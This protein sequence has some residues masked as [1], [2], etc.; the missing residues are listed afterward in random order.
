[1]ILGEVVGRVWS[2]RQHAGLDGRRLVLVRDPDSGA[3]HV[4]VDLLDA[5]AGMTVLLAT[6]E[7]AAIGLRH[8]LGRRRGGR[9][10]LRLRRPTRVMT[11]L[12]PARPRRGWVDGPPVQRAWTAAP[13][14]QAGP[15][16]VPRNG[17]WADGRTGPSTVGLGGP[18]TRRHLLGPLR[19]RSRSGPGASARAGLDGWR[20][21][22]STLGGCAT[23]PTGAAAGR[24]DER[25]VDRAAGRPGR[26][27]P[28][29]GRRQGRGAAAAAGA[30]RPGAGRVR[31]Q[32]GRVHRRPRRVHPGPDRGAAARVAARRRA[33]PGGGGRGGG[34]GG[35][36]GGGGRRPGAG[37]GA[38]RLHRAR[39]RARSRCA[40]RRRPRTRPTPPTPA[41]TT[42]TWSC[43]ARTPWRTRCAAAG[44]ACTPAVRCPT[45]A[46]A[47][48]AR[49]PWWCRAW[50]RPGRPA[51]S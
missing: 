25:R 16:R 19:H 33:G 35:R 43:T 49:W 8:P 13:L 40:P 9:P 29:A 26:R 14:I 36:A 28:R 22:A 23:H 12:R 37:R 32:H 44:P 47:T 18:S 6:D 3:R 27:G 42:A 38:R 11:A 39:A 50:C 24:R 21:G 1:M 10:R 17:R 48:R 30:R 51:C 45:G 15:G 31:G 5:A 4:A 20:I 7:A 2:E 34:P 41:S 46:S